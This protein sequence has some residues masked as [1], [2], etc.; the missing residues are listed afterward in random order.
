MQENTTRT[1]V[2]VH[3][4][5]LQPQTNLANGDGIL[6]AKPKFCN[7]IFKNKKY[8]NL[9]ERLRVRFHFNR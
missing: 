1:R 9:I 4:R 8:Q 3:K 5:A 2:K 6:F 7:E